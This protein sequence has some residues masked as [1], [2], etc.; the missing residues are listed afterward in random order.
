MNLWK[1]LFSHDHKEAIVT[2]HNLKGYD[3]YFL[4]EYMLRNGIKHNLI[5]SGSKIMV[6]NVQHGLDMRIIEDVWSPEFT[7]RRL[8]TFV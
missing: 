4:L 5:V 8:S 6:V 1:W 3:G 2:A 7:E